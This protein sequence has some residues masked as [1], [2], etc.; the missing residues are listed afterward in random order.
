MCLISYVSQERGRPGGSDVTGSQVTAV[1]HLM[2]LKIVWFSVVA[3]KQ[4]V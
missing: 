2:G 1:G 3:R 4:F